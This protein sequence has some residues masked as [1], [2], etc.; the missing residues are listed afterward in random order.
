MLIKYSHLASENF[1]NVFPSE[2]RCVLDQFSH[3]NEYES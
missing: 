1:F 2:L 3:L